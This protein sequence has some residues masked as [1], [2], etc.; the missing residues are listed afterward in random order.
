VPA[1][2]PNPLHKRRRSTRGDLAERASPNPKD[3]FIQSGDELSFRRASV[4]AQLL[5]QL[6]RGQF[7][8]EADIDLHG[9]SAQAA[10]ATLRRYL[11]SSLT[12]GHR[13]VRVVHGK[14]QR[15]G[16]LGPVIK[17]S[18]AFWLRHWEAVQ[19]FATTRPRDGGSGALLV[20]LD[21]L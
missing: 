20:L 14:G 15:S 11:Q 17:Q 8:I 7:L 18:V 12:A 10:E 19:A 3:A 5:H 1:T 21:K 4:P 16:P 2:P 9:L 13:C 6:R